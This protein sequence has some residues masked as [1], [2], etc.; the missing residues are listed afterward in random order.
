M[1]KSLA[2]LRKRFDQGLRDTW[3]EWDGHDFSGSPFKDIDE[4]HPFWGNA[5]INYDIGYLTGI[6]AAT[7]W[8]LTRPKS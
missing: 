7:G 4:S 1:A 5:G 6:S 8:S 2:A 3:N